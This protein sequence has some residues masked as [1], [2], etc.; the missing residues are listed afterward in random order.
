MLALAL[1]AAACGGDDDEDAGGGA[2]AP[3][4]ADATTST[5]EARDDGEAVQGGEITMGLEAETATYLPGAGTLSTGGYNV[6]YSIF[7]PLMARTAEGTVEP[8][9][10]ESLEPNEDLTEYTLT[11]REGV[12]FHD[13]TPLNAEAIKSNLDNHLKAPGSTQAG[14]LANVEAFEV[15]G[16]LTGVYR[17][18]NGSAAF[19]DLLTTIQGMPFSPTAAETM[20]DDFGSNPVGTGP[21]KFVS[22][23]RDDRLVVERYDDYWGEPAHLDRITFRP[24]PD[25]DT[26]LQSLISGDIDAM[27]SLRQALV[28]QA[29]AAE[30]QGQIETNVHIGNNGGGNVYNTLRPPVDDARVRLGLAHA[31]VQEDLIAVLGGEGISPAQTQFF[32]PDSPFYSETVAE[33]W[34]KYDPERASALLD[35]YVNDP[36]RSDGKA[37]GSPIAVEYTCPPDPSLIELAQ[38]YQAYWQAVG[39]E[40]TLKQLEQAAHIQNV[41]GAA[42]TDPPFIGDYMIACWRMGG[43]ADPYT[44]LSIAFGPVETTATNFTNYTSPTLAEQLDTLRSSTEVEERKAAVEAIGLEFAEQIPNSW[45]GAIVTVIGTR[46]E[47]NNIGGWTLPDGQE[48]TGAAEAITRWSQVWVEQ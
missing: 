46:P 1:V 4:G 20:G 15:T 21:F 35:E 11:L 37:P 45:T 16:E 30:E 7:D 23:A 39:V 42:T 38:A 18:T 31:I 12:T 13:G 48:G 33:A 32:S 5:T 8:F 2:A 40:V 24:I 22:W 43:Q 10:A 41:T 47:V 26:R 29:I 36:E 6:A 25:E 19:P 14:T 44:T 17:L 28:T 3:T 27:H 34:P 9:L